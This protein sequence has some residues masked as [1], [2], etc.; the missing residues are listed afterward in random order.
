LAIGDET[1]IDSFADNEGFNVKQNRWAR[2]AQLPSRHPDIAGGGISGAPYFVGGAQGVA[3]KA[4]PTKL[5][6]SCRE[7]VGRCRVSFGWPRIKRVPLARASET[8]DCTSFA[9]RARAAPR[10]V[11]GLADLS[12]DA[13]ARIYGCL[14]NPLLATRREKEIVLPAKNFLAL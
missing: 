11:A 4:P 3:P 1:T 12:Q 6:S 13:T 5:P 7:G 9:V 10:P 14:T 2:L 8:R